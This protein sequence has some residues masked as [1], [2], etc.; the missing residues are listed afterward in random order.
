MK[1]NDV[2]I[3]LI[4]QLGIVIVSMGIG[5]LAAPVVIAQE[6]LDQE[7]ATDPWNGG[8]TNILINNKVGQSFKPSCQNLVAVEVDMIYQEGAGSVTAKVLRD[9]EQIPGAH[10]QTNISESG[11]VK[12]TLDSI[13]GVTPDE[14]LVLQLESGTYPLPLWKYDTDT[15]PRGTRLFAGAPLEGDFFFRTYSTSCGTELPPAVKDALEGA[16]LESKDI[17]QEDL[18]ALVEADSNGVLKS[19]DPNTT[20]EQN[21]KLGVDGAFVFGKGAVLN[22]NLEGGGKS[23]VI[24][25]SDATVTENCAVKRLLTVGDNNEILGNVKSELTVKKLEGKA[26]L[27]IVRNFKGDALEV[28]PEDKIYID[29]N[30]NAKKIKLDSKASLDVG[31]D[32]TVKRELVLKSKASLVV[33]GNL[34]CASET[35]V[36]LPDGITAEELIKIVGDN[37]CPPLQ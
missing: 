12:L 20:Q 1:Q 15:Y 34:I 16:G 2:R 31:G 6:L 7:N 25:G 9:G 19:I 27:K 37:K 21:V 26:K 5:M 33:I 23:L 10:A 4:Q 13:V 11:W 14:T 17:P 3:K 30:G 24:F 29:G 8:S 35:S 22:A 36:E 32:L 28:G 18:D